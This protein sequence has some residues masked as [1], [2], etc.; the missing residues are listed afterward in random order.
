MQTLL[1]MVFMLMAFAGIVYTFAGI[2]GLAIGGYRTKTC[3]GS[4]TLGMAL[5]SVSM[6]LAK[7][8]I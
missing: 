8:F 3:I 1:E 7:R 5:L 4:W 2:A 6:I